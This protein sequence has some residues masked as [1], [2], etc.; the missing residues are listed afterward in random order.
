MSR[1]SA[2][3]AKAAGRSRS[4]PLLARFSTEGP[5]A[6]EL[7]VEC[8]LLPPLCFHACCDLDLDMAQAGKP[9]GVEQLPRKRLV[10]LPD[11]AVMIELFRVVVQRCAKTLLGAASVKG[12]TNMPNMRDWRLAR[13]LRP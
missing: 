7:R 9:R 11:D 3:A 8:D 12:L 10:G 2:A 1:M 4:R 13:S 6:V 5:R